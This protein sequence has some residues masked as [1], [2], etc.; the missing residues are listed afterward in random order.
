M[1]ISVCSDSF[2][3]SVASV[4]ASA[5][6]S[7]VVASVCGG[8]GGVE[9]DSEDIS[10]GVWFCDLFCDLFCFAGDGDVVIIRL[11]E[12]LFDAMAVGFR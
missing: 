10:V 2:D 11:R 8:S 4:S 3:V 1:G 5:S 6:I 12:V 9:V 7:A